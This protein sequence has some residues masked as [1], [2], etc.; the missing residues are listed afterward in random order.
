MTSVYFIGIVDARAFQNRRGDPFC[1]YAEGPARREQSTKTGLSYR[2]TNHRFSHTCQ[3]QEG[4]L[5]T[6][7]RTQI[8]SCRAQ[9]E[10]GNYHSIQGGKGNVDAIFWSRIKKLVKIV[11]PNWHCPEVGDLLLLTIFLVMRTFLSV[12][13]AT[14]NGRIVQAIIE[15]NLSLFIK[16]VNQ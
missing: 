6:S 12:Y 11:I 2:T 15:K 14:V 1:A 7:S 10:E 9:E 16:R 8:R 13:L 5:R 4:R 3:E